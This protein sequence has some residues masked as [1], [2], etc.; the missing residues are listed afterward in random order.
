MQEHNNIISSGG[1][2]CKASEPGNFF[3]DALVHGIKIQ[4]TTDNDNKVFLE[5]TPSIRIESY[6]P[7]LST[8]K[9][10]ESKLEIFNK[11]EGT[12]IRWDRD[13]YHKRIV[14]NLI[15]EYRK[16]YVTGSQGDH[17][18]DVRKSVSLL[19]VLMKI[20]ENGRDVKELK[21]NNRGK[22]TNVRTI[23]KYNLLSAIQR[24]VKNDLGRDIYKILI[25]KGRTESGRQIELKMKPFYR[26]VDERYRIIRFTEDIFKNEI[27]PDLFSY[28][29]IFASKITQ[30]SGEPAVREGIK[31]RNMKNRNSRYIEYHQSFI[32]DLKTILKIMAKKYGSIQIFAFTSSSEGLSYDYRGDDYL[33][34]DRANWVRS[35]LA[36]NIKYNKDT[37]KFEF[38]DSEFYKLLGGLLDGYYT[39]VIRTPGILFLC[40]YIYLIIKK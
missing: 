34:T 15:A 35:K 3:L 6:I 9:E 13:E 12:K 2:K 14:F 23:V 26:D 22:Y 5:N 32:V 17:M 29:N 7:H 11:K 25:N 8:L 40:F 30:I 21:N 1:F 36:F 27:E 28:I 16:W 4:V 31:N 10:V 38:A 19:N 24:I 39:F 18:A 33:S 37:N 20:W